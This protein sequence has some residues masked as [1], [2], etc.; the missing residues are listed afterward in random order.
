MT[1]GPSTSTKPRTFRIATRATTRAE[2]VDSF[3]RLVDEDSIFLAMASPP[4]VGRR[5]PFRITLEDGE[6]VLTGEGEIVEAVTDGRGRFARNGMRLRFVR[7]DDDARPVLRDLLA[8]KASMSPVRPATGRP[9]ALPGMPPPRALSEVPPSP[10]RVPGAILTLPANPLAELP[11]GALEHYIECVLYEDTGAHALEQAHPPEANAAEAPLRAAT[12]P[13]SGTPLPEPMALTPLPTPTP[14]PAPLPP[15]PVPGSFTPGPPPRAPSV[16][17]RRGE[18]PGASAIMPPGWASGETPAFEDEYEPER[19]H[20]LWKIL[21]LASAITLVIGVSL[22][23][24]LWG[25]RSHAKPSIAAGEAGAA[26]GAGAGAGAGAEPGAAP[27]AAAGAGSGAAPVAGSG[28][29]S[30]SA[31]VAG[32]GSGAAPVAATGAGAGAGSAPV[33]APATECVASITTTP[34]GVR[35]LVGTAVLGTT[36]I[37]A[38]H[39]PCTGTLVIDHPRYDRVE[40]PLALVPGKPGTINLVLQRPQALLTV[41]STPPGAAITLNGV[42]AGKTPATLKVPAFTNS[43]VALTLAGHKPWQQKVYVKAK[44]QALAA[45]LESSAPAKKT[46]LRPGAKKPAATAPK[47]KK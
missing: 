47:K 21:A 2:F 1:S 9:V 18:R 43:S 19:R 6:P 3:W 11:E 39:V 32:S 28:A 37:K 31:P 14:Q 20:K 30:G 46:W 12:P 34:A 5:H 36:P 35:A 29:A 22:G 45:P 38:A 8:R 41:T 15:P 24:I 10:A 17:S 16:A 23:W 44:K 27:V 7:L 40:K 26:P 13:P 25:G 4:A 33:A 42:A